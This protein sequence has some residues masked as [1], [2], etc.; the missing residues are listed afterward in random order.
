[1]NRVPDAVQ[2]LLTLLFAASAAYSADRYV[3]VL[4]APPLAKQINLKLASRAAAADTRARIVEMQ[5]AVRSAV[6]GTGARVTSANQTLVNAVFVEASPEQAAKLRQTPGVALVEKLPRLKMHLNRALDLV[7]VRTAWSSVNGEQNAG[8]GVRIAVIDSGIDQTHPAFQENGLQYPAGFPKCQEARGDCAFVNRKVI[9]ARSYVDMLVGSEPATSRPDDT[10]AR[11]RVG[12]GTAVA[13]IAA[14]ARNDG[15]AGSITGVAPRAWLGNYKVFGSPGVNGPYTYDSVIIQALEDAASDG[16]DIAVL[17]LGAPAVWGPLDR[18]ATCQNPGTEACDWRANAIENAAQMGLTIVVSAGNDGDFATRY[19]GYNSVETPGTA[20]S[21][22]TVGATTN[23]HILYQAV[24]VPGIERMGALFGDGPRPPNPLTA[25]LRDVARLQD[26]GK[27]CSSLTNGSLN[28]AI[29]LIERGDCSLISK[30]QTA[31]RAGAV[32]V[33]LFQGP[34][35]QGVF[36]MTGLEETGI[37]AVV[38]GNQNGQTLKSYASRT[39]DGPVTLDPAFYEVQTSEYDTMAFTSSRGPSIRESAIKPEVVAVGTD[40]YV[41]TQNFDPNGDMY[42]PT[43]YTVANGTSFAA[44]LVAGAAA[45]V[46]QRR[47]QWTPA[48]IKSAIVNTADP[49]IDDYD[50]SGN[51]IQASVLDIGA[52]KLNANDAVRTD[53]TIEPATLS[54]GVVASSNPSRLLTLRNFSGS[55]VSLTLQPRPSFGLPSILTLDRTRVDIPAG[56]SADIT[57]RLDGARP[58]PGVYEGV[59][60]IS[61]AAVPLRVPYLYLVGDGAPYSVLPL[62]GLGF[63]GT[64][65]Q[66]TYLT[67]KV[68]DRYGV[69]V[70]GVRTRARVV[71]GGGSISQESGETDDLGIGWADVNLGSQIG[72]QEFYVAVGDQ[73]NFGVYFDGRARLKP[74]I[75]SGGIVNLASGQVGQGLAP[76]S[77]ISIYGRG[78]SEATR[79]FSTPYLPLALSGVSVSFDVPSQNIHAPARVHYVRDDQINV[80]VPWELRGANSAAIKVSIGDTSSDVVTIPL[81]EYAP[82]VFEFTDTGSGRQLGA[83]LDSAYALVTPANPAKRNDVIQV[84]ANG[85]GPVDEQPETGQPSSAQPLARTRVQPEVT[86]GG[87]RAEV[88]F[89]GLTPGSIALYQINVRVPEGAPPGIQPLVVTANGIVSKTANLPVQ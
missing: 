2:K 87:Q 62:E 30:V 73:P 3:V 81:N 4:D 16:M 45:L 40:L 80:Q 53:L 8:A 64:A 86:I 29:A 88:L 61:G 9:A 11:D 21:A 19:P 70:R 82:A 42:D 13:M 85:L 38:V 31:Q 49:R 43:R 44:P 18:G 48:Q 68:V 46:K 76:G 15:P 54:F 52:G 84:Y 89:S 79:E 36:Q 60:N 17:S 55:P 56:G 7:T 41:A 14:G 67:Y 33:I 6:A 66:L 57:A 5:A 23:A 35:V 27:A 78:L 25:A 75:S 47:S 83:V 22:I 34:N 77:Y 24:Q 39:P 50:E 58:Q 63:E 59:I 51:F 1:M 72:D 26:N 28:G 20:P 74:T 37:P 32:G 10:S 71:F 65:G 69:P 12:H